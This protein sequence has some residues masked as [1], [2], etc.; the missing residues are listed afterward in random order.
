MAGSIIKLKA[1]DPRYCQRARS[2]NRERAGAIR[3]STLKTI[4]ED[5]PLLPVI[6]EQ[7]RFILSGMT[8]VYSVLS[9][10]SKEQL[11][12]EILVIL[13]GSYG[14]SSCL[15]G[16]DLDINFFHLSDHRRLPALEGSVKETFAELFDFPIDQIHP[17]LAESLDT[18]E[19]RLQE[20]MD[21]RGVA[22]V[23][24]NG[25]R[26]ILL[27]TGLERFGSRLYA[28][29]SPIL[30]EY[31]ERSWQSF[32]ARYLAKLH[33]ER[34]TPGRRLLR[35]YYIDN[36]TNTKYLLGDAASFNAF[37]RERDISFRDLRAGDERP[38]NL[39]R[40]IFREAQAALADLKQGKKAE[41][42]AD[43]L[44]DLCRFIKWNALLPYYYINAAESILGRDLLKGRRPETEKAADNLHKI[45][46]AINI[47]GNPSP[48]LGPAKAV[49][50]DASDAQIMRA[51][52]GYFG[53]TTRA[54]LLDMVEP[55]MEMI[56][57]NIAD[58]ALSLDAFIPL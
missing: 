19:P 13:S 21:L 16:S 20:L 33:R 55:Q 31:S 25:A 39:S 29:F 46:A 2:L 9:G 30:T 15:T 51:M 37:V 50:F 6:S 44:W 7:S 56:L 53:C 52:S 36:Y 4:R 49:G 40:V 32:S 48:T 17:N 34:F 24:R 45:K 23:V 35:Q 14:R 43:N 41:S 58:T 3:A 42:A 54:G 26:E 38:R 18:A 1:L 5:K 57:T 8:D 11:D 47:I 22:E 27:G 28:A 10:D 12:H